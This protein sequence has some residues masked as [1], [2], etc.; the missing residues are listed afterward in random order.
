MRLPSILSLAM[1]SVTTAA[2]ID[3]NIVTKSDTH[4]QT[5]RTGAS[6]NALMK[7]NKNLEHAK[8]QGDAWRANPDAWIWREF[9]RGGEGVEEVW[10]TR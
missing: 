3:H 7:A 2:P 1:L 4:E 5:E 6:I 10:G 9:L 8:R